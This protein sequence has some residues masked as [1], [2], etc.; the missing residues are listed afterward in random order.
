MYLSIVVPVYNEE[1]SLPILVE[2]I[3]AVCAEHAYEKE[4]I[5]VDDGSKDTSWSVI[6]ALAEKYPEIRAIRFRRNFGKAAGLE[7]GFAAAQG[8]FIMTMDADLQDDPAEIPN[9]LA[10]L[11]EGFDVVSGWKKVRHDPWHKVYPS[12]V[13]NKMVSNLTGVHLHDHNCGMK[14]YR[15]EVVRELTIY[16]ERHRFLP[17][18]AGA[19]GW[20][21]SEIIVQHRK[22]EFGHSKYG[23]SRFMKGFMDLYSVRFATAYGQRPQHVMGVYGTFAAAFGFFLFFLSGIGIAAHH[24]YWNF[25][26]KT[27]PQFWSQLLFYAGIGV[28]FFSM[29]MIL[30]G[31]VFFAVGLAAELMTSFHQQPHAENYAVSERIK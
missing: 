8:D 10:K 21:V 30:L 20:R 2:Q 7:A 6:T 3:Q 17:V 31:G 9:F 29:L 12:R 16:G 1:E 4:I 15:A 5:F 14:C 13:F 28:F 22:R 18:L 19:R 27:E 23:F 25:V 26:Q 11:A 24:Y